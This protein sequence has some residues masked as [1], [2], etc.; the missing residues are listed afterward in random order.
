MPAQKSRK[1]RQNNVGGDEVES[2]LPESTNAAASEERTAKNTEVKKKK[3]YGGKGLSGDIFNDAAMENA[4]Y[5]CHNV[6]VMIIKIGKM[7]H[8]H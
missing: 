7:P 1:K 4:Y 3:N 6:Q 5:I 2:P 8:F